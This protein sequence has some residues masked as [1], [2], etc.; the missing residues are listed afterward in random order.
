VAAL[1]TRQIK[2]NKFGKVLYEICPKTTIKAFR[3]YI[4]DTINIRHHKLYSSK[5]EAILLGEKRMVKALVCGA[6]GRMGSLI[7]QVIHDTEGIEL[8]GALEQPGHKSVG[9][10]A[11]LVAG[12]GPLGIKIT[13]RI[14]EVIDQA[15]VI[16]DFT[17]PEATKNMVLAAQKHR[18]PM[19]IGTTALP[20][21][22]VSEIR[23]L[24]EQAPVVQSPNMSIGVNLLFA[25]LPQIAQVLGESYDIEIIEAH[26]RL[27]KDA[28][29][30]TAIKMAQVLAKARGLDLAKA[31]RYGRQGLPGERERG[32]I[33]I[34]AV[35]GGDIIG[36]HT[37]LFA[38]DAERIEITHRAHSRRTFACG[39]VRAALFVARH[40]VAGLYDMKEILGL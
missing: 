5:S 24:A 30:G 26:H 19:V 7:I 6:A 37:V 18:K 3:S 32:E 23:K 15:Q 31:A 25:L 22:V 10:D 12:V 4:S 27:K 20:D 34:H 28:P 33:G 1:L 9:E 8:S 2:A 40:Q 35:R 16:I 29:S 39:A 17:T 14:E 21:E 38:G 11:G 36:E 13:D